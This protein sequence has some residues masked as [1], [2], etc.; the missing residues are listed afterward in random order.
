V[1]FAHIPVVYRGQ[2]TIVP[3]DGDRVPTRSSDS[4]TISGI[5]SPAYSITL[6][7]V[8]RFGGGHVAPPLLEGGAGLTRTSIPPEIL[9]SVRR[10][11]RVDRSARDRPVA[12]IPGSPGLSEGGGPFYRRPVGKRRQF[13]R[14]HQ[15]NESYLVLS[16]GDA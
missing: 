6:L 9:E 12:A 13:C 15:S 3:G 1:D 5:T 4:A 10:Q 16:Q 7:E 11:G 14:S 8:L 2:L